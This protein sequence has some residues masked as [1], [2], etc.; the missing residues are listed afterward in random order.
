[1]D[2][3][4]TDP[5]EKRRQ[6]LELGGQVDPAPPTESTIRRL[7]SWIRVAGTAIGAVL[8]VLVFNLAVFLFFFMPPAPG[9]LWA[10]AVGALFLWWHA[11]SGPDGTSRELA[12]RI[13]LRAPRASP[14][15]LAGITLSTI[16]LMLG[17]AQ[18]VERATGPLDIQDSPFFQDVLTYSESLSGW[19]TFTF[20]A[21]VVIPIIEEFA[22]RGRLQGVMEEEW[23]QPAVAVI[24]AAALFALVHI[25][26]P[27]PLL[28]I[29]PFFMGVLC[30]TAVILSRSIWAGVLLHGVWNGLM[31]GLS[32]LPDRLPA[33]DEVPTGLEG[34]GLLLATVMIVVGGMGWL[35]LARTLQRDGPGGRTEMGL[36]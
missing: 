36:D 32:R 11:R 31:T 34:T 1:M 2:D 30:G 27:H 16:L 35:H 5:P 20:A 19:L 8:L 10:G 3:Q 12:R 29:V 9:A 22:F 6:G 14:G 17:I 28:L 21:A 7:P 33:P 25:G 15:W 13:R 26:G 18:F 4:S 24:A 23:D